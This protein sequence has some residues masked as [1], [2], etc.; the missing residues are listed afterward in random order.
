MHVKKAS[1]SREPASARCT[2]HELPGHLLRE[3]TRGREASAMRRHD[4]ARLHGLQFD[5]GSPRLLRCVVAKV[6]PADDCSD[7]THTR[8]APRVLPPT[9]GHTRLDHATDGTEFEQATSS[10]RTRTARKTLLRL[11]TTSP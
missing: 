9:P 5:D 3:Q 6:N 7:I 2:S 4:R 1:D 8:V 10:R 11:R